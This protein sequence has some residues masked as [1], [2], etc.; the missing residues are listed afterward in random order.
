MITRT[1]LVAL[2]LSAIGATAATMLPVAANAAPVVTAN[3][4]APAAVA[5]AAADAG[6]TGTYQGTMDD[7]NAGGTLVA[8]TGYYWN[9]TSMCVVVV[10]QNNLYGQST[11]IDILAN[12]H[13]LTTGAWT[14]P[15]DSE[16]VLYYAGPFYVNGVNA[17]INFETDLWNANGVET[18]QDYNGSAFCH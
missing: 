4:S 17:C 13:N 10:K 15:A 14:Y 1:K 18:V 5:A 9:G 6:C 11:R 2:A 16:T 3:A 8:D 12:R 7:Y